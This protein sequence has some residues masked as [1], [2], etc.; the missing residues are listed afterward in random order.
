MATLEFL[1]WTRS[2]LLAAAE[3]DG[4]R[5]KG[6]LPLVL[7]DATT[8][9]GQQISDNV[10]VRFTSASEVGGL[11]ASAIRHMA[12]KPATSDAET[13][14]LVHVDFNDVD[15]P[16]R[17]SPRRVERTPPL[18]KQLFFPWIA[19]LV[20]T[21]DELQIEGALVKSVAGVV[22][23]DHDLEHSYRWAH[24]QTEGGVTISRLLS[25]RTLLPQ[26]QYVA[27]V[28][29]VFDAAGEF[30]WTGAALNVDVL[31]VFF[32]WP[33]RTG[34]E[35][36]FETLATALK[37]RKAGDL[38]RADLRYRRPVADV[39][40][41][42]HAR[43]A[44]TSLKPDVSRLQPLL[45]NDAEVLDALRALK[46]LPG[47]L[48]PDSQTAA[49]RRQLLTTLVTDAVDRIA[50]GRDDLDVLNDAVVDERPRG[51]VPPP[52]MRK[53]ISLPAYGGLWLEDTDAAK[54][55]K[56][57]ND[58]PRHRGVAGLGLWMGIVEQ[59]SLM[60]AA[61][62]QAGALQDAAQRI[63]HLALGLD[64]AGRLWGRRLPDAPALRLR[65]FG[66]AMGRMLAADGGTVLGRVTSDTSAL[67][68]AFFSSAAQRLMRNGTTMARLSREGRIDRGAMLAAANET[69]AAVGKN[70]KGLPHVDT[71]ARVLDQRPY[72]EA[73][74]LPEFDGRLE[75]L[76]RAFDGQPNTDQTAGEFSR[77]VVG[78][79]GLERC[80]DF[81]V[82][83]LRR[84]ISPTPEVLD[85]EV[86]LGAIEQCIGQG[87][88][89][90]AQEAGLGG[91]LPRPP[92]ADPRRPIN[93]EALASAVASAIDPTVERPPAWV[94][95]TST[96][97]GLDLK[98][99]AP[100]EAP[101]GLDYPTW[102]LLNQ[103]ERE[104]LLPGVGALERDSIVALKTN[105]TFIDAFMVG[106]NTQFISE[107]RWR[108]LPAPRVS[109]P[110]RMFWGYIN[111]DTGKRE[112]DIQP[113]GE[114][115]SKPP[116]ASD[117]DDIGALSHQA[118]KPGDTTGKEDLI[119]V[120]RTPL[121]RRYPSTLVYLVRPPAGADADQ[122]DQLLKAPPRFD[123]S[124][125]DRTLRRYFGPIFFG[126]M[127]PDLVFFAF[128]VHPDTLD[129]YW[130]VLDEPP[131]ELRFRNDQGL[132][133]ANGAEFAS[134]TI[135][136]PTRVAISGEELERQA[137]A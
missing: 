61:V 112:A 65:V 51:V 37:L 72:E 80:G 98:S 16:W 104:W 27:A 99:L 60:D 81:I 6:V 109:T 114:W 68:T 121:F 13:T 64:A 9:P 23:S 134:K 69:P 19:L 86:L 66:P 90:H 84:G 77:R 33:F 110:L 100:P 92:I 17:Y 132:E 85:R 15:L 70:P 87:L 56:S 88:E 11:K 89:Q 41:T 79:L 26:R 28:V 93:L 48:D 42:L 73:L 63:G 44:I 45:M 131:A 36:D 133:W 62:R 115:P 30:L 46:P 8:T 136:R 52:P 127:E 123:D 97:E 108:N 55:S 74:G 25:P 128:D 58:D 20:G 82:E 54:W 96:I 5:L 10:P 137:N 124:P 59:E 105:P 35:G 71:V 31:P 43:G 111:H 116:A 118:I 24:V 126:Q 53:I 94:R 83:F 12:P 67:D 95:V 125:T 102:T 47:D 50:I 120:F 75:R 39:D 117:A 4:G 7:D 113:I 78:E 38:G 40:V 34:E 32:S 76:L 101:I 18:P 103:H 129:Q 1:S 2:K 49:E 29:P 119:I 122:V 21:T 135:D 130:L 107:M 106:I 22:L 14:K 91:A 57:L 3:R